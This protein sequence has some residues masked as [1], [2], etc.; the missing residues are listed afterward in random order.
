MKEHIIHQQQ[1]HYV[2]EVHKCGEIYILQ[3]VIHYSM[4][5]DVLEKQFMQ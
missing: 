2:Q 1:V 4:N 5:K 3:V